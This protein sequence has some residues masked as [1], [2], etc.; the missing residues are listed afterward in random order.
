MGGKFRS[1]LAVLLAAVI[2][3]AVGWVLYAVWRSPHRA[4][5][6]TYGAFALALVLAAGGWVALVWRARKKQG[7]RTLGR[8]DLGGLAAKLADA[9]GKQW[10]GAAR[11]RGLLEPIPVH[12]QVPS[13]AMAGPASSAVRSKQ[14]PPLPGLRA[15]GQQRLRA[16]DIGD[17]HAIYGGLGS[18]RLVIAGAPGAGKSGAAVFLLLAALKYRKQV[19]DAECSQVPVPLLFTA[20]DWDPVGQ[21]VQDWLVLRMQRTYPLF[22]GKAGALNAAELITAGKIAVILD[23]LD[24]MAEKLRAVALQALNQQAG[25]RVV[26]L[27]RSAEMAA[28]VSEKG[29]LVGAAAV[30]L[31]NI[32]P[33]TAAKYLESV[34]IGAPEGWTDLV[35][36][37]RRAPES[38]LAQ[39]LDNPLTLTLVRDIYRSGDDVREFLKFCDTAREGVSD[40][41]LV[42]DIVGFLLDGVLPAAYMARPGD[43]RAS[44][45]LDVVQRAFANIAARMN[46]D[47]TRD[48]TLWDLRRWMPDSPRY[49]IYGISVGLT[50]GVMAGVI[51]WLM[52]GVRH[53]VLV[54][55]AAGVVY[56]VFFGRSFR[57]IYLR[58]PKPRRYVEGPEP[59]PQRFRRT[60]QVLRN[61]LLVVPMAEFLVVFT[62]A[63]AVFASTFGLAEG[64]VRALVVG[65][66]TA[67]VTVIGQASGSAFSA[68]Q[69]GRGPFKD[70]RA[71]R[72]RSDSLSPLTSWRRDLTNQ[73]A[74]ELSFA[75]AIAFVSG[76]VIGVVFGLAHGVVAAVIVL[77]ANV[78]SAGLDILASWPL[79]FAQLAARWHTPFRFLRFLE[80]ARERNVLRTVGPVY[81]FRHARL[82]DRLA[83]QAV[84]PVLARDPSTA[85]S[86]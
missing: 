18:G 27:T 5:L 45:D 10:E 11:E 57:W 26:V 30:E 46:E 6:A 22:E 75:F 68:W 4:D 1:L 79:T 28:A 38:P 20:L 67:T 55:T 8:Q 17:L 54:G 50:T 72:N 65:V 12:W 29:V 34:Q 51:A 81:Q 19:A 21:T 78:C 2:V 70:R 82:Q 24:E 23:G 35:N 71:L 15:V 80:D 42:E 7:A 14:F 59:S 61:P 33:A 44:C 48:L 39:A 84:A 73:L 40:G 31:Q 86:V 41:A 3:A 83:E 49:K 64:F 69:T 76:I 77:I 13:I 53:G 43:G 9:V 66:A 62:V 63:W 60:F 52:A 85:T 47:F 74:L 37:I 16:G 36:R 58:R 56:G 32:G 25:F